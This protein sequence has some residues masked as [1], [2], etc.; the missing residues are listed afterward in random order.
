MEEE[1]RES[2]ARGAF[3]IDTVGVLFLTDVDENY[4]PHASSKI[5]RPHDLERPHAGMRT[6]SSSSPR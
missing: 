5:K 6:L 2:E 1:L 3:Q 4:G